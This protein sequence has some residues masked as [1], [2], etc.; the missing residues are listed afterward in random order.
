MSA[1]DRTS[2]VY[3]EFCVLRTTY[4]CSA[5]QRELQMAARLILEPYS[6][7]LMV[8][9]F[10]ILENKIFHNIPVYITPF[11]AE[12]HPHFDKTPPVQPIRNQIPFFVNLP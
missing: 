8:T 2:R 5:L 10:P 12:I 11:L 3:R 6:L 9:I 1:Q 4:A 7:F